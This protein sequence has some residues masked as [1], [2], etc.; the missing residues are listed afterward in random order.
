[1]PD[2]E[3]KWPSEN[4]EFDTAG[5]IISPEF[6]FAGAGAGE[7]VAESSDYGAEVN[8][9]EV[10]GSEGGETAPEEPTSSEPAG[11]APE[12]S[13]AP[14]TPVAP[15]APETRTSTSGS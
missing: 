7:G 8:Y 10:G 6:A 15:A 2:I 5:Q 11:N 12:P 9:D 13:A 4:E 1:M 14:E 3:V